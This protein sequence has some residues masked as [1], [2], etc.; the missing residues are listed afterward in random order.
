MQFVRLRHLPIRGIPAESTQTTA[1]AACLSGQCFTV[2]EAAVA[3]ELLSVHLPFGGRQPWRWVGGHGQEESFVRLGIQ[4]PQ[5]RKGDPSR[6]HVQEP[7][8]GPFSQCMP[9]RAPVEP[10]IQGL[11][12]FAAVRATGG[13]APL[14]GHLLHDGAP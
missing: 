7:L 8:Q 14:C 9:V 1:Q 12:R 4:G 5:P 6:Q 2:D 10:V 11:H 3:V 13:L